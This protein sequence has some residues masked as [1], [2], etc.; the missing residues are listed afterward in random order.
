[1]VVVDEVGGVDGQTLMV[2]VT[3]A[4]TELPPAGDWLITTPTLAAVQPV[5]A[6]WAATPRP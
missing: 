6:V 3:P 1:M 5:L 4:W 2:T